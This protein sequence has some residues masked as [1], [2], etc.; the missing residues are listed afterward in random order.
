MH[1]VIE[2]PSGSG[3][4]QYGGIHATNVF[5]LQF[6]NVARQALLGVMEDDD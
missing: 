3:N 4:V 6:N 5:K 1:N 2:L